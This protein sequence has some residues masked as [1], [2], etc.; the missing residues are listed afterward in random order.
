MAGIR[1]RDRM[2]NEDMRIIQ[3]NK[4]LERLVH[5]S[6]LGAYGHKQR[7]VDDRLVKNMIVA[8]ATINDS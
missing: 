2:K 4:S 1:R 8:F 7:M 5:E 6:L 3:V